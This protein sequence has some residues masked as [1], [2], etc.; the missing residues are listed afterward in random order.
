[1]WRA[2]RSIARSADEHCRGHRSYRPFGRLAV[3]DR[4]SAE[5]CSARLRGR[6]HQRGSRPSARRRWLGAGHAEARQLG[7]RPARGRGRVLGFQAHPIQGLC[8]Q[9]CRPHPVRL[10]QQRKAGRRRSEAL[11]RPGPGGPDRYRCAGRPCM[12]WSRTDQFRPARSGDGPADGKASLHQGLEARPA[13]RC[14][15]HGDP[16]SLTQGWRNRAG[17]Q[18]GT[19]GE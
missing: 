14:G 13:R 2:R 18:L 3:S 12:G 11:C 8:P 17:V 19:P 6:A 15:R 5:R 16:L 1:M 10:H 9:G 4:R 7:R